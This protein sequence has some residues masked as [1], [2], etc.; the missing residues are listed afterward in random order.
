MTFKSNALIDY[1][2]WNTAWIAAV[3]LVGICRGMDGSNVRLGECNAE[4]N[5][6]KLTKWARCG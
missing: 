2:D 4:E 6:L 1:F 3:S 5:I